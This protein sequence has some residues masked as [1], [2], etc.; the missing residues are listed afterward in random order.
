MNELST[1]CQLGETRA[2]GLRVMLMEVAEDEDE[3]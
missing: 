3:D 2:G 1:A